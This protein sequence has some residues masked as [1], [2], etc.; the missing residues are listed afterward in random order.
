MADPAGQPPCRPLRRTRG[1]G[2]RTAGRAR[3]ARP[4]R[5]GLRPARYI[6]RKGTPAGARAGV[7][8]TYPTETSTASGTAR[9]PETAPRP[10][11]PGAARRAPRSPNWASTGPGDPL[12]HSC[13]SASVPRPGSVGETRKSSVCGRTRRDVCSPRAAATRRRRHPGVLA[14]GGFCSPGAASSDRRARPVR[15]PGRDRLHRGQLHVRGR[16]C[17]VVLRQEIHRW[18]AGGGDLSD[19]ETEK[20]FEGVITCPRSPGPGGRTRPC[21]TGR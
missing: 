13:C 21:E 7:Q 14:G 10:T 4:S 16:L 3:A 8:E 19:E 1:A 15:G 11:R 20:R 17:P 5:T 9:R 12:S 2:E 18:H 6:A